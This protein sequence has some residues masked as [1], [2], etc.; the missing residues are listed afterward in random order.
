MRFGRT[1]RFVCGGRGLIFGL[2]ADDESLI[3]QRQQLRE[4]ARP[5]MLTSFVCDKVLA[6][7]DCHMTQIALL[8]VNGDRVIRRVS[9]AVGFVIAADETLLAPQ[10]VNQFPRSEEHIGFDIC[11]TG[12]CSR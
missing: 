4:Q 12:S 2:E 8:A 7:F 1:G 10:E 6:N 11:P 3:C 9:H 5:P